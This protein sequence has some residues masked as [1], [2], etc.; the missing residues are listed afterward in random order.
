ME[1]ATLTAEYEGNDVVAIAKNLVYV[2]VFKQFFIEVFYDAANPAGNPLATVA[3]AKMNY[4]LKSARALADCGGDLLFVAQTMEGSS[5]VARIQR[6]EPQRLD[7][8]VERIL[9]AANFGTVYSWAAKIEGHRFY[10]LTLPLSNLT[11]VYDITAQYWY[12]WTDTDGD[13]LPYAYSVIDTNGKTL[14]LHESSGETFNLDAL[15]FS[16]DG[17]LFSCEIYTPNFSQDMRTKISGRFD[18]IG[19]RV[20]DSTAELRWSDDD[21]ATWSAVQ[22]LD[23]SL[24]RPSVSDMGSFYR[25][26]FH[27]KHRA[28]KPFRVEKAVI[29]TAGGA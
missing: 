9:E 1:A 21:Y 17:Q 22:E 24:E 28:D 4:G 18:L 26:A 23:L 20:T 14:F 13:Y 25:R 15:T 29:Y 6:A 3:G 10:G 7:P 16:D 5:A 2:I 12:Q 8:A 27:L 11:L 19:D